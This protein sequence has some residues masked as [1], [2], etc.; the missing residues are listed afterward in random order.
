MGSS[1]LFSLRLIALLLVETQSMSS[2]LELSPYDGVVLVVPV[3][4]VAAVAVAVGVV[5]VAAAAGE[6]L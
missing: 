3:A 1:T 4:V 2:I 5:V 6:W